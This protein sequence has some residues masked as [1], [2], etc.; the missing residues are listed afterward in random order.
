M[1]QH[2]VITNIYGAFRHFCR[3][4]LKYYEKVKR[5]NVARSLFFNKA[6]SSTRKDEKVL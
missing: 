1:R 3:G 4:R 5:G 6:N 2:S